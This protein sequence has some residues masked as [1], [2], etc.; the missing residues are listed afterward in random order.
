MT[1]RLDRFDELRGLSIIGVVAIHAAS[2][3]ISAVGGGGGEYWL[4][5]LL[6]LLG[7][8][9]VPSFL[10]LSGF[11]ISYKEKQGGFGDL[12][13]NALK[14][15]FRIIPPY[16]FWSSVYFLAFVLL[17]V[18]Y[19]RP[20]I[21]IFLEKLATGTVA[22]HL[23]FIVLIIQ[24]YFLS[25]IGFM[26][27]GEISRLGIVLTIGAFLLFAIPSYIIEVDG[28]ELSKAS[29]YFKS[30]E[31][32]FFPRWLVYFAFGR[33]VGAHWTVVQEYATRHRRAIKMSLIGS[34]LLCAAEFLCLRFFSSNA[35]FLPTDWMISCLPFGSL[36]AL[37][38]LTRAPLF[39]QVSVKLRNLGVA[40][41]GVYLLH[42]PLLT[43]LM[44]CKYLPIGISAEPFVIIRQ[45]F[46]IMIGIAVPLLLMA[47]F[48]K[49]LPGKMRRYILG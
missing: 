37:W 42:E 34:F 40:S 25:Y 46:F 49:L 26:R 8:F 4:L 12:R 45:P 44:Q 31:R 33:W 15:G 30:L 3:D 24:M 21:Q 28:G 48:H 1:E 10:I 5:S 9:A 17:G 14:R 18:Q 20:P 29:Y 22:L 43:I 27:N 47:V 38:F 6:T 39:G 16:V 13:R 7:R 23:Y 41:F 35:L 32:S 19:S 11:F 2:H 36:F